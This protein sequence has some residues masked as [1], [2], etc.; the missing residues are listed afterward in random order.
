MLQW[1]R[2]QLG[3]LASA[4]L[5]QKMADASQSLGAARPGWLAWGPACA[6]AVRGCRAGNLPPVSSCFLLV[7]FE[8]SLLFECLLDVHHLAQLLHTVEQQVSLLDGRLVQ[9]R[10]GVGPAEKVMG[11]R[12]P[13]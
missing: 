6:V 7:A 4:L 13:G 9:S 1:R 8:Y 3:W 2:V 11:R 10:L 5:G 12:G